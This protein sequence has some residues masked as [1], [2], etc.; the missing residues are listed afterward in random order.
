MPVFLL[1]VIPGCIVEGYTYA[2]SLHIATVYEINR[3]LGICISVYGRKKE[4]MDKHIIVQDVEHGIQYRVTNSLVGISKV[5]IRALNVLLPS[6]SSA[7]G[8][9]KVQRQEAYNDNGQYSSSDAGIQSRPVVGGVN[10]S[11]KLLEKS[12]PTNDSKILLT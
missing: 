9:A 11:V 1:V 6:R 2:L 12:F 4:V 5:L 7:V 10:A 3:L 8:K